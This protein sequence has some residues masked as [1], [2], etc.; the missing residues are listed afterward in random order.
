MRILIVDDSRAMRMIVKRALREA[1]YG[2]AEVF[3]GSDGNEGLALAKTNN[4]DIIL[5]DWNMPNCG[6]LDFL[7]QLRETPYAGRFGYVTSAA[8]DEMRT[9]A[10]ELKADFV[11][12]KPFSAERFKDALA[13]KDPDESG[14]SGSAVISA[15]RSVQTAPLSAQLCQRLISS[16]LRRNFQARDTK[17]GSSA[18]DPIVAVFST[19]DEP[20]LAA[21]IVERE[22]ACYLGAALSLFPKK[23]AEDAMKASALPERVHE[24]LHEVLNLFCQTMGGASGAQVQLRTIE[25]DPRRGKALAGR[26]TRMD[27]VAHVEITIEGYGRGILTLCR[28]KVEAPVPA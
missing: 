2:S 10:K 12:A 14:D 11:I 6:G 5:S 8:T 21:A 7:R 19:A 9:A 17:R 27:D 15:A 4:P 26:F 16:M 22:L 20:F 25:S 23:V 1:G 24:N 13:G 18:R 3:E 28:A